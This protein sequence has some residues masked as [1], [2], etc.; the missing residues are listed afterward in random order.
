MSTSS[1]DPNAK[2]DV[3]AR[4]GTRTSF[5]D[6]VGGIEAPWAVIDL[7]GPRACT[8]TVTAVSFDGDGLQ[9]GQNP[10]DVL[11]ELDDAKTNGADPAPGAP[12]DASLASFSS[13]VTANLGYPDTG[14]GDV[15]T[16]RTLIASRFLKLKYV[17]YTG[18]ENEL[19]AGEARPAFR[20]RIDVEV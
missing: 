12:T 7:G 11:L 8:I 20:I 4:H 2:R 1:Q 5:L 18:D 13:E 10:E 3:L 17:V 9:L 15:L 16:R 6:I 19:Y 14:L